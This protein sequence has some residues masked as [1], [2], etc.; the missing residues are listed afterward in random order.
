MSSAS[1]PSRAPAS[2]RR[3]SASSALRVRRERERLVVGD[4]EPAQRV[5]GVRVPRGRALDVGSQPCVEEREAD[6]RSGVS[7]RARGRRHPP[8]PRVRSPGF[9]TTSGPDSGAPRCWSVWATS[10]AISSRPD[11]GPGL[12]LPGREEDVRAGRE[13]ARRDRAGERRGGRVR[14]HAHVGDRV[15]ERVAERLGEAAVE[16]AAA[17]ARRG[18]GGLDRRVGD[19][20]GQ[21][22]LAVLH[23]RDQL[24]EGLVADARGELGV[25]RRLVR[26]GAQAPRRRA[27]GRARVRRRRLREHSRARAYGHPPPAC[28]CP[29]G[30][31]FSASRLRAA[32]RRG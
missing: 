21:D 30:Q 17:A 19:A 13:R 22:A 25:G 11:G 29:S 28:K 31:R 18:D 5:A 1:S 8:G 3:A 16:R 14:V 9:E 24:A 2:A 15:A 32:A 12:V 4:V 10:W 27:R 6:G 23:A 26:R 20:A 7:R